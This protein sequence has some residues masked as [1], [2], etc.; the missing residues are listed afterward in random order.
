M[1]VLSHQIDQAS[2]Q[3]EARDQEEQ[4]GNKAGLVRRFNTEE[5]LSRCDQQNVDHRGESAAGHPHAEVVHVADQHLATQGLSEERG[6]GDSGALDP[7]PAVQEGER[8]TGEAGGKRV[9]KPVVEPGNLRDLVQLIRHVLDS[10]GLPVQRCDVVVD[11]VDLVCVHAHEALLGE[12]RAERAVRVRSRD[13]LRVR[14]LCSVLRN[15]D[16]ARKISHR[17][18]D[19]IGT[20]AKRQKHLAESEDYLGLM[21]KAIVRR[22]TL[23]EDLIF[24]TVVVRPV[25]MCRSDHGYSIARKSAKRG[26]RWSVTCGVSSTGRQA[27]NRAANPGAPYIR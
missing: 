24:A 26:R 7:S 5:V 25:Q 9:G 2:H 10:H 27:R 13:D 8:R 17:L 15:T 6:N 22:H 20:R 3:R 14:N 16:S 1:E 12:L 23:G 11:S 4:R 21:G 18:L 19:T